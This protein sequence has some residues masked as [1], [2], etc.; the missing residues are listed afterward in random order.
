MK[1]N[2]K[3]MPV[4]LS[5]QPWKLTFPGKILVALICILPF[6][7]RNFELPTSDAMQRAYFLVDTVKSDFEQFFRQLVL[8]V[9]SVLALGWFC[10]E[11][12]TLRPR[13]KLPMTKLTAAMMIAMGLHLVLGLLSTLFSP[14]Q[15]DCWFGIYMMYEGYAALAS[16]GIIFAAAW[17]WSD[18][19]EVIDFVKVCLTVL[20]I[21]IGVLT[22][23]EKMGICYYNNFFVQLL[24]GLKGDV[25]IGDAAV[26]TF[27]NADYLGMYCAMLLPVMVSLISR[28]SKTGRMMTQITAAVL[29]GASLLLTKV[30]NAIVIGFGMTL[31]LLIVWMLR[32]KWK[33]TAKI[34]CSGS[35]VAVLLIGCFGF[36]TTREGGSFS[37]KLHHTMVG[38][39]QAENFRLL[40]MDIDGNAI[41]LKNDDTTFSVITDSDTLSAETIHFFCNGTEV[42]PIVNENQFSF[43]ESELTYC[44]A[45]LTDQTLYLKLG[46]PTPIE[47]ARL[48]GKW[49]VVGIGGVMLEEIPLVSNSQALQKM[50]PYLNGRVFVWVN[51]ISLLGDCL[52]IGH[53][54]CTSIYYLNQNDLPALLNIF[55]RYVLYNKPH[56]WYLQI[57]QDTGVLSLAAVLLVL[58]LFMIRGCGCCFGKKQKWDSFR[59]GVLFAV[60]SYCLCGIF[61]DSLVYHAPMFWFLLGFGLRL[62]EPQQE[63]QGKLV[64]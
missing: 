34:I 60:A 12:I 31:L 8:M 57:A 19:Q 53:G 32:G 26:V 7:T 37:E 30:M 45:E 15:S 48:D 13:R 18:R 28:E 42:V 56:C 47:T 2:Q 3:R 33:R 55:G 27:G 25:G 21:V 63:V 43:V 24:S 62:M 9:I 4:K 51:T 22:L 23:L 61:N 35:A 46:Y 17:Y 44:T 11:R 10:Y 39:E 50:Y 41:N 5:A 40:S 6:L 64:S 16:Y 59:T 58:V 1:N 38:M 14:Y 52:F 20:S 36:V 49:Q 29:V 54:P